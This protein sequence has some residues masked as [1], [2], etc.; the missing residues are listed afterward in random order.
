ML[1]VL[2]L[3]TRTLLKAYVAISETLKFQVTPKM[4]KVKAIWEKATPDL[5]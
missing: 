1:Q 4:L 3:D 5:L 2:Y